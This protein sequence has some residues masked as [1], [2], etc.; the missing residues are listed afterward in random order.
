MAKR[1][2]R[3]SKQKQNKSDATYKS[4]PQETTDTGLSRR[5]FLKGLSTGAV[6]A[7]MDPTQLATADSHRN[8]DG[9][10]EGTITLNIN[11]K[12]YKVSVESRTTLLTVLRDSNDT[13]GQ[14]LDLTGAKEI[15]DQGACGGCTVMID[16]KSV[17]SC[18]ML[19][20]EAEGKAI[21]TVEGLANAGELHPI[22]SAFVEHDALMCGFCTPGFVIASKALLDKNPNP[23]QDEIQKGLSGNICRCGTYP[24]IFEAVSSAAKKI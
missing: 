9:I 21:T 7:S 3:S 8:S 19:A 20:I 16:G 24:F 18:M 15:C 6:A 2:D 22:Q 12:M 23:T 10:T 17:Y 11:Q 13:K 5:N 4:S 14:R 1:K